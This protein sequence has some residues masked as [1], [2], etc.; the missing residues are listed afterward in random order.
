MITR[1]TR[2]EADWFAHWLLA[3]DTPLPTK[4]VYQIGIPHPETIIDFSL[5]PPFR[6]ENPHDEPLSDAQKKT[7]EN[8]LLTG[9]SE[10]TP[11]NF[12]IYAGYFDDDWGLSQGFNEPEGTWTLGGN[13]NYVLFQAP[14]KDSLFSA[15]EKRWNNVNFTELNYVWPSDHE[16]FLASPPDCAYSIIG[17]DNTTLVRALTTSTITTINF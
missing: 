17:T 16:W 7:L 3:A 2:R 1:I 12:A 6:H 4:Y 11:C 15:T 5:T 14:L 8:I 10:Q 13:T 9:F